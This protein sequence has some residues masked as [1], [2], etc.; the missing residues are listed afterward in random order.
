MRVFR[1]TNTLTDF[2][3]KNIHALTLKAK[4]EALKIETGFV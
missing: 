1:T 3:L 2:L 4:A